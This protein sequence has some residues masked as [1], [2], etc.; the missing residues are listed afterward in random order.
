MP[1]WIEDLETIQ[2]QRLGATRNS[3][4]GRPNPL[5]D[6]P[7]RAPLAPQLLDRLALASIKGTPQP[8]RA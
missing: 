8:L 3:A 2:A 7:V 4:Q 6:F 5:G 1:G